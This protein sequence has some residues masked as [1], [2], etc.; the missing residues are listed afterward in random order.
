MK[1]PVAGEHRHGR[2]QRAAPLP[3]ASMRSSAV[4]A[5]KW[6]TGRSPGSSW[7]GA[8]WTMAR[9]VAPPQIEQSGGEP[10]SHV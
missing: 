6:G 5:M 9:S 3:Q 1:W 4:S 10:W 8:V 7:R 2:P